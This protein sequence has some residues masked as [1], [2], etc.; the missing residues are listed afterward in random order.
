MKIVSYKRHY[1]A[2][3]KQKEIKKET[4]KDIRIIQTRNR[5]ILMLP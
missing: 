1:Q 4:G 3:R 2:K 5:Y